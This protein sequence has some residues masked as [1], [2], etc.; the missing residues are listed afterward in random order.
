MEHTGNKPQ[1][2]ATTVTQFVF[3]GFSELPNL[4][5]FLFGMLS[6]MYVIILIGNSF[7]IVIVRTDP[8][9]Q[10]PM[11][12]YNLWTQD[13]RI[14]LL[15]CA[16][17]LLFFLILAT[18]ECFLLTV[19]SYDRYVAICNPLHYLLVMN[20]TKCTQM[21]V[22][23]WLGGIPIQIGQTCGIFSQ[24]FCHSNRIDH[25]FCDI[26]PILKLA[27]GETSVNELSVY[28]L[29]MGKIIA[30]I[31]KLPTAT[32]QAKAFS[33][34][35]S[36]L[37][38]VVLFFGSAT[39]NYFR[40]KSIHSP[41][42]DGILSLFYTVVTPMLNPLIYSLRNKDAF[43]MMSFLFADKT[44]DIDEEVIAF[45][46]DSSPQMEYTENKQQDNFTTVTQFLFV[47]FSDLPNIQGFLFGMFSITYMIILIGNSFIIVIVRID[48]AL[49]KPMYFFLANFSFL[50]ICYVSVT[51]P[52]ILYNLWTQDRS[53]CLLACASQLFF[54]LILATTECFLLAVMSYDR[55]VAI[56]NPLHYPLVMNP[57]KC[58]QMAVGSWLGGIPIQIGQ[59]CQI[60][61]LH[62]CYS[63][64]IDHFFCDILPILKLACGD[65]SRHE[66][67]VYLVVMLF[68]VFPFVLILASYSKIIA[69]ILKLP[70]ATGR[71][72]AFSTCSSHLVVVVLFFA[73]GIIYYWKPN[74]I[75][76][77]VTD[78]V[79]SLFYTTVTPTFNPFIYSLRNKDVIAALR[80]V[81]LKM[82]LYSTWTE[83]RSIS[84]PSATQ[85][86]FFLVLAATES[87][88]LTVMSYDHYVAICSSLN[89]PLVMNP[90]KCT[91]LT[92]GSWLGGMPF[93]LG[94]TYQIFSL[95]FCKSNKIY[96]FFCDVPLVLKMACG[97]ISLNELYVYV[98]AILLSAIP[99]ILIL[100]SYSKI[101]ATI[102]RLP[103]AQGW[104]KAFSTCSSHL[105]VVI[106]FCLCIYYLLNAK[107][108][109]FCI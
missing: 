87:I 15:A 51:L 100:T 68:A 45:L 70:T 102:L 90:T 57:T 60:F 34:C 67:S 47:G 30:T 6:V 105:V 20:P 48:P 28:I 88:L 2:N 72:K 93:Q 7:I 39:I 29:V 86:C 59:T 101:I 81:L 96:H 108:S 71:A 98:V 99:F 95:Y 26:P 75:N 64:R 46:F 52:R 8:A 1:D 106:V 33:T 42:T 35:S 13:R 17:Q 104:A 53:I 12:L 9:L 43:S 38:V 21:A 5:G 56:C 24:C 77:V 97:D 91:L 78:E 50:E 94:Q 3:L 61:S 65:T 49:Q 41:V 79:L 37:V 31:V 80:K 54:F 69:T 76:S 22:G 58:T 89:Y 92:V 73:S 27:C 109:T 84:L 55:Y 25:F 14:C 83:D 62:F 63:N 11:I 85:M 19:M 16:L 40:P 66:L 103:T 44:I 4:Q 74:A 82:I 18:T 107:D 23:S 36:H 10:K 32:G